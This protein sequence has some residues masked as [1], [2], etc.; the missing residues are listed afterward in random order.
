MTTPIITWIFSSAGSFVVTLEVMDNN[1]AISPYSTTVSV[2]EVQKGIPGF[3]IVLV[4]IA[5]LIGLYLY[6]KSV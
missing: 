5:L 6:R 3:D 2:K 1:D 4:F